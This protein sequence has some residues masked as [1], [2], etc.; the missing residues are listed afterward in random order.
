MTVNARCVLAA[1]CT[2]FLVTPS[3]TAAQDS[4]TA[5]EVI[6]KTHEA[7][8][9][10][11]REKAAGIDTFKTMNSRFVWKDDG[12]VFVVDCDHG[13][14][15]AN[16][17]FPRNNGRSLENIRDH[18]GQR[19]GQLYC[20]Y[21][22]RLGGGWFSASVPKPGQFR[23]VRKLIFVRP[24]PGTTYQVCSGIYSETADLAELEKL[25]RVP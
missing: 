16:P 23:P 8:E 22:K 21:G 11:A 14:M 10:L 19:D 18:N 6:Q 1:I 20:K 13:K 5:E 2:W 12:Y 4:A 7:A 25:S 15:L 24:V 17:A 9:Y 3:W